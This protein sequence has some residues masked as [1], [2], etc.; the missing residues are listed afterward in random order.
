[1]DQQ[2]P[3]LDLYDHHTIVANKRGTIPPAQREAIVQ[4]LSTALQSSINTTLGGQRRTPWGFRY[5]HRVKR[6][7]DRGQ[8]AA[9]EGEITLA[10]QFQPTATAAQPPTLRFPTWS[11]APGELAPG[12][13]QLFYLPDADF[14]LSAQLLSSTPDAAAPTAALA[15]ASA[16]PAS[17]KDLPEDLA[18]NLARANG[19]DLTALSANRAG[20]LGAAQQ[21]ALLAHAGMQRAQALFAGGLCLGMAGL[22]AWII[23]SGRAGGGSLAWCLLIGL[24]VAAVGVSLL[25][26]NDRYGKAVRAGQVAA[27]E[28]NGM[29]RKWVDTQRQYY[30]YHI[31]VSSFPVSARAYDAFSEHQVYRA[32]CLPGT[33][34]LINI[35]PVSRSAAITQAARPQA[36]RDATS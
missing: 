17:I 18:E 14:V 33:D 24:I 25:R 29:R 16:A 31:G 2:R 32:Y 9:I 7:L 10:G 27:V 4:F 5:P 22:V 12:R 23:V 28:G 21:R 20:R 35:E 6:A 34:R 15:P 26:N 36:L 19:F 13:Y 3:I 1:M 11:G 8:V 30:A